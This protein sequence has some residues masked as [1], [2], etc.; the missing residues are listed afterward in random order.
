MRQNY[1][2][3]AAAIVAVT[4][5]TPMAIGS[6]QIA[7]GKLNVKGTIPLDWPTHI[8]VPVAVPVNTPL[9]EHNCLTAQ[10]SIDEQPGTIEIPAQ[11]EP[12]DQIMLT[13]ARVWFFFKAYKNQLGKGMSIRFIP[14]K[15]QQAV[16]VYYS[17]YNRP[18]LHVRSQDAKPILSYW[19]GQPEPGHRH[20]LTDFI[21]P[22]MGLNGEVLTE[23]RPKDHPHHRALF[24]AWVRHEIDGKN[25]GDWWHPRSIS[26]EPENIQFHDGKLL[27][28]FTATHYWVHK[29][30]KTK[31]EVKF[32]R[33][34][35]K[36]RIFK[37]TPAG[38]AI[39]MDFALTGLIDGV[40]IGGT[41]SLKKGYGGFTIRFARAKD[42]LIRADGKI[43]AGTLVNRLRAKWVDFSAVFPPF[44]GDPASNNQPNPAGRAGVAFLVPPEHP[45]FPPEWITRSLGILNVS[46]PGLDMLALHKDKAFRLKYRIWIHRGDA[47]KGRVADHYRSYTADWK[48]SPP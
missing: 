5:I 41:T 9:P 40:R 37:T 36:C 48:W 32:V 21:H 35:T 44:N 20:M 22:L 15:N 31:K 45:H 3:F 14:D 24:W 43:V 25:I 18:Q 26:L 27:S 2:L 6:G 29:P 39:D 47:P 46:Y 23:I 8:A 13:P 28:Y 16:P 17:Q 34:V 30:E 11:Y 38:R 4:G 42:P 33:E 19:H 12:P 7:D 10:I 1:R